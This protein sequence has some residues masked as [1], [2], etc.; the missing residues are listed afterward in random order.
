MVALVGSCLSLL[1]GIGWATIEYNICGISTNHSIAKWTIMGLMVVVGLVGIA[2]ML[3]LLSG[4]FWELLLGPIIELL[5]RRCQGNVEETTSEQFYQIFMLLWMVIALGV[6]NFLIQ[7]LPLQHQNRCEDWF[8]WLMFTLLFRGGV[9]LVPTLIWTLIWFVA[10]EC[11]CSYWKQRWSAAVYE[12]NV[13]Q[14]K[15]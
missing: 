6:P 3:V 8:T 15:Q 13:G 10:H 14:E 11:D 1:T 7:H 2:F 9:F 12:T 5:K 4:I